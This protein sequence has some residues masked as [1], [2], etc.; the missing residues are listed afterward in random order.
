[1]DTQREDLVAVL[2]SMKLAQAQLRTLKREFAQDL[3]KETAIQDL[4]VAIDLLAKKLNGLL[5]KDP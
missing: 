3:D 1:M 2:R 5:P 4:E